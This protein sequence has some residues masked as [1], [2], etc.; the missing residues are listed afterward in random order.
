VGF[1][2]IASENPS[3]L[4]VVEPDGTEIT[5]G[6]LLAGANQLVHGLRALG[7]QP[8]GCIAT[9]LDN[10]AAMLEAFLA[11]TQAGWYVVPINWHLTAS[12]IAYILEDSTASA[13]IATDRVGET[14]AAAADSIGF[15]VNARFAARGAIRGFRPLAELKAGQPTTLPTD[16]KAGAS[17]TYTSGTTGKPKGVR[18][19]LPPAPPE[20]VAMQQAM[21]LQLFGIA[22]GSPGVHF[23][24]AP[25][26]HT[27]VLNFATNHLHLGHTLVLVDKWDPEEMLRLI[28]KYRVTSSHMVPTQ[29]I[30]LLKLPEETRRRYDLSSL[31]HMIHGAAP[32]SVDT[33]QKMLDWWGDCI[34]EYYAA[35]EGGGTLSTPAEARKK[36]GSVGKPWP[37]SQIR[38]LDDAHQPVAAGTPGTVWIKMGD[39]RFE[40]HKDGKKTEDSW[41]DGFFTVGDAGYVDSD[42][43]LYLCDRKA[44]MIISG[45]VN[46]YPAEIEAVL[47]AHP[48]VADAA[49]FGIPDE[50]WGEQVKAVI[51]PVD[52]STSG[53]ALAAALQD[54]AAAK[55][56]KFKLP[57]SIDFIAEMPRDPNGKLYKRKLRDPY[58]QG[59]DRAI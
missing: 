32:C 43:Y 18:R 9:V 29:F 39:H 4:A 21:F 28:E 46:I 19:G 2:Q 57:K 47:L 20:P 11:A 25:L 23:V 10:S 51:Q 42:G 45:G 58:W 16:R 27:A 14:V 56:A 55:L 15:P 53:D 5:A 41:R 37:I 50:D 44:D 59:R 34:F 24:G 36:P 33:K 54:Y 48:A 13:L 35:S 6:A 30:R 38:I 17:M 12:E 52:A 22:P 26:Y 49:V 40:Y 8:G 3:R 7:L 1:W 31:S